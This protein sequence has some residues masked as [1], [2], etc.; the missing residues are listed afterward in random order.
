[1]V[2]P[3]VATLAF[4]LLAVWS[5]APAAQDKKEKDKDK[6]AATTWVRDVNEIALK[7]EMGKDTLKLHALAGENGCVLTCKTTTDKDGTIKATVTE[8]EEKG[9]F[10]PTP[11]KGFEFSFKWKET[12]DK[13]ELSDLKGQG[14]E[15]A[16]AL[17]EGEYKKPTKGKKD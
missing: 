1:M 5:A 3:L 8:V 9:N 12:G 10:P 14:L 7:F 17:V 11:K 13:A 16:K 6:P 2:R 15:E 4:A